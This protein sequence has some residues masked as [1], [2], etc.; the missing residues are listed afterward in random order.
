MDA[1]LRA[2]RD[3]IDGHQALQ[4]RLETIQAQIA[5][6]ATVVRTM[7]DYARRPALHHDE[8]DVGALVE[9]VCEIS[10]PA[11]RA[12][13]VDLRITIEPALP[14]LVGDPTQLELAFL[15]LVSNA[16][17]AMAGGGLLEV[18][19]TAVPGGVRLTVRDT[20]AGIP[21]DV[22]PRIFEPWVTTK[23]AGR[24]TGLGLSITRDVVISHGGSITV[25]SDSGHGSVFTLHLPAS[26]SREGSKDTVCIES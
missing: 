10:R 24:G 4:Q 11:L 25:R 8:V 3:G 7:L 18:S 14:S 15:N 16:L 17:D 26:A 22:L 9:Q 23:P 20:G 21:P 19:V 13:G 1:N 2:F 5:K 6:V 12:A